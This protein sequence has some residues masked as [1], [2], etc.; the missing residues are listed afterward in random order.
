MTI[1]IIIGVCVI[2]LTIGGY[3]IFK[4][5]NKSNIPDAPKPIEPTGTTEPVNTDEPSIPDEPIIPV[6]PVICDSSTH[7][8]YGIS[9]SSKITN[10]RILVGTYDINDK[11]ECKWEI[12]KAS[13]GIDFLDDFIFVNGEI[14]AKVIIPNIGEE[15][16]TRYITKHNGK[17]GYKEDYFDVTQE[18]GYDSE[19]E[20]YIDVFKQYVTINRWSNL[21]KYLYEIYLECKSQFYDNISINDLP[22]LYVE[23]NFPNVY[24]YYGNNGTEDKSF[25]TMVGWSFALVITELMPYKRADILKIGYELGGYNKYSNIF[26]YQF[27]TDPN[28]ARLV[29]SSIYVTL[30]SKIK[31]DFDKLREEVGGYKYSK[32]LQKLYDDYN[33]NQVEE[34][35]FFTDFSKFMPSAPGPYNVGYTTRPDN[36]YPNEMKE[37][38]KNLS[39]DLTIHQMIVENYNLDNPKYFQRTVQ[40]IA[41]KEWDAHHLYGDN[42][43]YKQYTF[44]PVFGKDTI[45][46][47]LNP[48]GS[49]VNLIDLVKNSG[50]ASRGILQSTKTNPPTYGRLRPGCSWEKECTKHSTT[51]D[52]YNVL[53]NFEIEDNDGCETGYYNKSGKWVYPEIKSEKDFCEYFKKQVYA[54]SYPSGH[55]SGIWA[56]AMVLMELM[57]NKA[58]KIMK[59]ANDFAINRTITRFHW[60][61]DTINGRVIGSAQNAVC[62][63]ASD[64]DQLLTEAKKDI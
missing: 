15:R 48:E 47:K 3:F 43:T 59:A 52:R 36:T 10:E 33:R 18:T 31:P 61:S 32:T 56:A 51:D 24:N 53:C 63:A 44:H 57:P 17:G 12:V 22:Q 8:L 34:K 28:I 21:Y 7:R 39:I 6:E 49:Y 16:T 30:R 20:S 1:A 2:G 58:N 60:T 55:S 62:H 42:I 38:N 26:G 13:E 50:S 19:F 37:S 11:C 25:K 29:G 45:G 5:N 35:Q 40:A 9:I 27:K 4:N 54:N 46:I 23:S 14:K 41:D 64:W